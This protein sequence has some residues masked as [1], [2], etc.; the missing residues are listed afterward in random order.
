MFRLAA[1]RVSSR[2][3]ALFVVGWLGTCKVLDHALVPDMR[4]NAPPWLGDLM[5]YIICPVH[6]PSV[7]VS[8]MQNIG[9][10]KEQQTGFVWFHIFP[11]NRV[12]MSACQIS[13]RLNSKLLETAAGMGVQS[14]CE[15]GLEWREGAVDCLDCDR[16]PVIDQ[17]AEVSSVSPSPS[18]RSNGVRCDQAC[19]ASP[20]FY[21]AHRV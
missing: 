19:R 11:A 4:R 16:E 15:S 5:I 9:K 8:R 2:S 1:N 7:C 3:S 21:H 20:L 13:R 6:C 10:R 14:S 17:R 18:T 12:T